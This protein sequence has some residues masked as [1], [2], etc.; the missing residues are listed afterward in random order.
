MKKEEF[1][2]SLKLCLEHR[3]NCK[4]L[5]VQL[6]PEKT[7]NKMFAACF[8][9]VTGVRSWG[10]TGYVQGLG[11]NGQMGGQAYYRAEWETFELVGNAYW[12]TELEAQ[13]ID[14]EP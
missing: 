14:K 11:E 9:V 10:L 8:M 12:I 2:E 7:K 6:H 5:V 13:T 3:P 4:G 1:Q